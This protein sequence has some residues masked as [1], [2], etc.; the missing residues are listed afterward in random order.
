MEQK[1][2]VTEVIAEE[3][4]SSLR[5]RGYCVDVKLDLSHTQLLSIIGGYDALIVRSATTVD[6]ELLQAGERLK[7]VGRAGVTTDNI[8]I[9]A[10][11]D[12]DIIV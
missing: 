2:L 5:A 12:L 11:N 10:A 9:E 3:G 8:D 7:V 4:L 6:R 1:I